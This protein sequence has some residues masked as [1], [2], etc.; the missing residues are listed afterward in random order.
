MDALTAIMIIE[1]PTESTTHEQVMEAYQ[2]LHDSRIGYQLQGSY[3][4]ALSALIGRG[5]ITDTVQQ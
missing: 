1:E 4:R 3:G 5:L 2:F